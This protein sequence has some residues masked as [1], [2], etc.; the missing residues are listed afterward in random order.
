MWA[1]LNMLDICELPAASKVQSPDT[2][3]IISKWPHFRF[4]QLVLVNAFK[5][6]HY[7]LLFMV[8]FLMTFLELSHDCMRTL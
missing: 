5:R 6:R 7:K 4:L 2:P 1:L 8:D 3:H